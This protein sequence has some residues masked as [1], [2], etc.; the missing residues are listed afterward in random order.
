MIVAWDDLV[1]G[2]FFLRFRIGCHLCC[3]RCFPKVSLSSLVTNTCAPGTAMALA[4]LIHAFLTRSNPVL[5]LSLRVLMTSGCSSSTNTDAFQSISGWNTASQGYSRIISSSPR[6]ITKN[7]IS[8]TFRSTSDLEIDKISND[9]CFIV[10]YI[11]IPDGSWLWEFQAPSLHV[12]Q[13]FGAD[14]I[15]CS[16]RVN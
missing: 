14:E 15:V 6:S 2:L 11:N 10:H 5:I 9:S 1:P 7:H 4:C 3:C 12:L 13:D 16:T 8:L